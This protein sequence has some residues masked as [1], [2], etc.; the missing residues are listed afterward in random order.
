MT[1]TFGKDFNIVSYSRTKEEIKDYVKRPGMIFRKFGYV[2]NAMPTLP[3]TQDE[4]QD[5]ADYIDSLQPFKKW[6]K[7]TP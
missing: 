2:A 6:M 4:I 7:K 3:L 1:N 5:V